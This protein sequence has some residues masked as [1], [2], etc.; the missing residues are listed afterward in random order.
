MRK[1]EKNLVG[2]VE[3]RGRD[4]SD[5]VRALSSGKVFGVHG[6]FRVPLG[7]SCEEILF[8]L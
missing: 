6:V 7:A 3:K 5:E 8:L 1:P 4:S 2:L